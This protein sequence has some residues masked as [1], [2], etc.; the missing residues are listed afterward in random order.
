MTHE[1]LSTHTV[2]DGAT[3]T[4][5]TRT[6]TIVSEHTEVLAEPVDKVPGVVENV[7]KSLRDYW[8]PS[9]SSFTSH[10]A[11]HE[12]DDDEN[13]EDEPEPHQNPSL[14]RDNSVMRRAYDYWRSLTQ[15]AD[16]V[17]KK[18]VI[19]AK[20]TRDKAAAEA[21]W[22]YLGYKKEA[23]EAFEVAE[24][25]YQ[26]ALAYAERVHDEAHEHAKSKWFSAVDKTEQEVGAIK[27]EASEITHKKWDRFKAAVNSMAFNPP[28]YG[29]SPSSQ[30]WFSRQNPALDSGWDCR[31]IWDHPARNDHR[32][33]SLKQLPKKQLPIEKVHDTLT[34]LFHQ[35]GKKSRSASPSSALTTFETSLKPLR[36]YYHN[37]LARVSRGEEEAVEELDLVADKIRAKLN[38]AKFYEEQTDAWLSSQWAAVIHNAGD[39]KNEYERA[40]K[41]TITTIKKTRAEIYNALLN[42]LQRNVNLARNNIKQAL[43]TTKDNQAERAHKLQVAVKDATDNFI[44]T[45][46]EA[47]AKIKAAPKKMYDIAIESYEKETAHLRAKLEHAASVASKSATSMSNKASKSA[48]SISNKASKSGFSIAHQASKSASSAA[49]R[50]S[51]SVSSAVHR[52][53]DDAKSIVE[54]A[55]DNIREGYEQASATASSIYGSATPFTHKVHDK[56]RKSLDD[57]KSNL[58]TQPTTNEMDV[59]T[60]YGLLLLLYVVFM[61]YRVWVGKKAKRMTDPS[62]KSFSVI[63]SVPQSNGGGTNSVAES[64]AVAIE[65]F[66]QRPALETA[67]E[68]DRNWLG[69]AFVQYAAPLPMT[70][71]LLMLLELGGCNPTVLHSLGAG[72]ATAQLFQF[73]FFD[74]AMTK[75]GMIDGVNTTGRE[76]GIYLSWAAIAVAAFVNLVKIL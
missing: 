57:A 25:K 40:F 21:K 46:R 55:T 67:L 37:L 34:D 35:A 43:R 15:D 74:G 12:D 7:R 4:I 11:D 50:A 38:E 14:F 66:K 39:T 75:M 5:V 49:A 1:T 18:L 48:T 60:V 29:C 3:T 28:K 52:A 51:K 45:I 6:T 64:D 76:V 70:L 8:F 68:N 62:E 72:I 23:R 20:I 26:D 2:K 73:G 63:K 16:E 53:T 9:S 71:V 54:D 30:Y 61:S 13:D 41:N 27:D 24:K 69:E 65:K 36:D 32:H 58:F 31:E 56:Y 22:A 47:D 59:S 17:A 44:S 42:N 33:Q 10:T 19:E